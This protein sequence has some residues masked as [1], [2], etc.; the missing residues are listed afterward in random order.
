MTEL[1]VRSWRTI[2]RRSKRES[3]F[4]GELAG[5]DSHFFLTMPCGGRVSRKLVGTAS[6][7]SLLGH[8][9]PILVVAPV[10][11]ESG[12]TNH[13]HISLLLSTRLS[14][15]CVVCSKLV[16]NLGWC[17]VFTYIYPSITFRSIWIHMH[18]TAAI[19]GAPEHLLSL[20]MIKT[21]ECNLSSR[22]VECEAP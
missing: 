10:S 7:G 19:L 15:P 11:F 3:P 4:V 2:Q 17:E 1:P 20:K 18:R 16:V 22:L 6:N 5:T 8:P 12:R 9:P 21:R 13:P 14:R